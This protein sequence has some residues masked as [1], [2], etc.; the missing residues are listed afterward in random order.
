[1]KDTGK[2]TICMEKEFIA[3]KMEENMMENIIWIRSMDMDLID[4]QIEEYT[5]GCG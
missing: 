3:G 2:I 1:M 4:G 5:K